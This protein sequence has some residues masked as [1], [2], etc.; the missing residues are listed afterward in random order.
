[1]DRPSILVVGSAN[2]DLVVTAEQLPKPGE[3]LLGHRF[4]TFSGGKGANQAVAAARAGGKVAMIAR[5]GTDGFGKRLVDDLAASGVDTSEI[6]YVDEP[7]GVALIV[8]AANGE[9]AIVVAPGA[10]K[11]LDAAA[12]DEVMPKMTHVTHVLVQLETP[13]DGVIRAAQWARDLGATF[14]LDPAPAQPLSKQLLELTDWITPNEREASTLL[15][16][17]KKELD[18]FEAVRALQ[19]LGPRNVIL[20]MSSKGAVVLV[21]NTDPVHVRPVPVTAVDT[22]AAGDAFNGAFAVALSEGR[23]P[24]EAAEFA[25]AAAA[26]SVTRRGAQP[27]MPTRG[28]IDAI[29]QL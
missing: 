28:E 21:G 9:N 23:S 6:R 14:V 16:L 17:E 25:A 27:S 1:M 8:T 11:H 19:A 22:T 18:S 24:V 26:L 20:K 5:V 29:T 2:V 3:T 4:Q 12:I 13:L 15:G 10:N 7:S